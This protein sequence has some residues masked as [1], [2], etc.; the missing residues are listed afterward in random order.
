MS[1]GEVESHFAT[2]KVT[3]KTRATD[4]FRNLEHGDIVFTA[5]RSEISKLQFPKEK[6]TGLI[7][8]EQVAKSDEMFIISPEDWDDLASKYRVEPTGP[9]DEALA[10]FER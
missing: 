5:Q 3:G 9:L 1:Y 8:R 7:N 10:E 4:K 6:K 2:L